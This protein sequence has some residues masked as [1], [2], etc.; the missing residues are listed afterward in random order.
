MNTNIADDLAY[1]REIA[2]SGA[3]APSL[4]GRYLVMWGILMSA[5]M[6]I[7]WSIISNLLP[8]GGQSMLLALWIGAGVLGTIGN[9]VITATLKSRPGGSA[10]H[11]KVDKVV[12]PVAG[13]GMFACFLGVTLAVMLRSAPPILFDMLLPIAFLS[14][15]VAFAGRA[16]FSGEAV[17]W[18]QVIGSVVLV[19]FTIFLVGTPTLYLVA[20]LGIFGLTVIPGILQIREEPSMIV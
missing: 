3:R 9:F 13:A 5:T 11:N 18:A 7:H 4:G 14:Y 19:A 6:V 2:E 17:N 15:A 10:A 12:W 8:V 20:A 1:V 16:A